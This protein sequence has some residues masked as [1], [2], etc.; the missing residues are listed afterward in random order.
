MNDSPL[1][2]LQMVNSLRAL[3]AAGEPG[4]LRELIDEFLQAAPDRLAR[5]ALLARERNT[6][7]LE[8]EAH[9]LAG[10]CGALGL[11]QLRLLC[12]QAEKAAAAG[13]VDTHAV[14]ALGPAFERTREQLLPLR[15]SASNQDL[16]TG[17]Q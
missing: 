1:V 9:A 12:R 16:S 5:L 2:D 15:E 8:A 14:D 3:E 7:A 11:E 4:L 6:A 13:T 17:P 10:S